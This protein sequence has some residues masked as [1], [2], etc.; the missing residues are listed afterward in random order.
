MFLNYF[1][2]LCGA[3][4]L[5]ATLISVGC[6][7]EPNN[8]VTPT[9][10]PTACGSIKKVKN[11][12]V[13]ELQY[14]YDAQGNLTK[15]VLYQN[16][17][18][19]RAFSIKRNAAGKIIE[20]I[21]STASVK[22]LTV[23]Q[24]GT[25]GRISSG[26]L[27]RTQ[28]GT[29]NIIPVTYKY[30]GNNITTIIRRPTTAFAATD[31]IIYAYNAANKVTKATS[32]NLI[33]GLSFLAYDITYNYDANGNHIGYVTSGTT[34]VYTLDTNKPAALPALYRNGESAAF[35]ST[36]AVDDMLTSKRVIS[37]TTNGT[38][39]TIAD[40]NDSNGCLSSFVQTTAGSPV[41][42]RTIER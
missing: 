34:S 26:Q 16:G 1:K 5:S 9:P 27:T 35:F 36:L 7:P 14:T 42:T 13:L 33:S 39:T 41:I 38:V 25:N 6:K 17:V 8:D 32:Y 3:A 2:T 19:A 40:T 29:T 31:S 37:Y 18:F 23:V 30:T 21:D 15:T 10:T 11:N 4:L 20:N 22:D 28:S 12:G 24:Y